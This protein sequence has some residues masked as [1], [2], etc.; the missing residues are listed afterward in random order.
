MSAPPVEHD[1]VT[2][3]AE[4]QRVDGPE[5]ARGDWSGIESGLLGRADTSPDQFKIFLYIEARTLCLK[6]DQV[7]GKAA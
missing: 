1:A 6:T 7:L 2:L 5:H 3:F 4:L